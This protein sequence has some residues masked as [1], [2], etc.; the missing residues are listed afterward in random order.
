MRE[1]GCERKREIDERE[2]GKYIYREG[3]RV[4]DRKIFEYNASNY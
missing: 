2:R 3:D 4:R 1:R